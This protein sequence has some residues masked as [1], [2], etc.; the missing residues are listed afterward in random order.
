MMR[1]GKAV[2]SQNCGLIPLKEVIERVKRNIFLCYVLE[3][4]H[5][6]TVIKMI[7]QE[8]AIANWCNEVGQLLNGDCAL[9]C[10]I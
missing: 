7:S 2:S 8:R 5:L 4:I 9:K 6:Q 10:C 3:T 1:N